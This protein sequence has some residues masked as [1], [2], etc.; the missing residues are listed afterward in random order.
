MAPLVRHAEIDPEEIERVAPKQIE[1]GSG[2][3]AW[4]SCQVVAKCLERSGARH[5]IHIV[6]AGRLSM[7][8]RKRA[9]K[10]ARN[11]SSL[12]HHA[13]L[14]MPAAQED[15]VNVRRRPC[16]IRINDERAAAAAVQPLPDRR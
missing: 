9:V 6:Q 5:A 15:T 10:M 2:S 11:G 13:I 7:P 3:P 4:R 1:H 8:A 12:Q 14:K 16:E